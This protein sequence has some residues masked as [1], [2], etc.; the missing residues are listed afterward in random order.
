MN[1]GQKFTLS[2]DEEM[3]R[4]FPGSLARWKA[5]T[6]P[7]AVPGGD[8]LDASP[9]PYREV[10]GLPVVSAEEWDR[11]A[12]KYPADE[13]VETGRAWPVRQGEGS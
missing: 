1:A 11:V 9:E 12:D 5:I 4:M 2:V 10:D 13:T 8:D 6:A 7:D 3:E